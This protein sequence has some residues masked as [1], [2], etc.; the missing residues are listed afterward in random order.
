MEYP[1]GTEYNT[2]VIDGV[3]QKDA[4]NKLCEIRERI[5]LEAIMKLLNL[6]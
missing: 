1:T 6:K 5:Y 2:V 4:Y 3:I